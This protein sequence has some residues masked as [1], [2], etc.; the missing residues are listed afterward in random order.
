LYNMQSVIDKGLS[1]RD[2]SDCLETSWNLLKFLTDARFRSERLELLLVKH[3]HEGEVNHAVANEVD[4]TTRKL[5]QARIDT[6]AR[7]ALCLQ[8]LGLSTID[9][10]GDTE[11]LRKVPEA[12]KLYKQVR[13]IMQYPSPECAHPECQ[14]FWH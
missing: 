5:R 9:T 7:F 8:R 4:L 11:S 14:E 10:R 6:I 3:L 2:L 13:R 12:F 1:R